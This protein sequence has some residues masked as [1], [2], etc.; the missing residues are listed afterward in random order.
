MSRFT[1]LAPTERPD[2]LNAV[3]QPADAPQVDRATIP[4]IARL[5]WPDRIEWRAV[6]ARRWTRDAVLVSWPPTGHEH[7][8]WCWLPVADVRRV[9]EVENPTSEGMDAPRSP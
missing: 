2:P 4:L 3:P 6:H 9:M 1:R 7:G 5:V 8:Q